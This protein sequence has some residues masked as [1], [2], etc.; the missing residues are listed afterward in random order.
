M[1]DILRC[2]GQGIQVCIEIAMMAADAG[3]VTSDAECVVIAGTGHGA[4][5]AVILTP[6]PSTRL[7]DLTVHEILCK[8]ALR[9]ES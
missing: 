3:L 1:G 8:P 9:A 5:T 2:F 7:E 4:D 6:A